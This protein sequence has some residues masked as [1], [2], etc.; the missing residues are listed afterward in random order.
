MAFELR[1]KSVFSFYKILLFDS[2][3]NTIIITYTIINTTKLN[4]LRINLSF[5]GY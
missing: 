4:F 5:K 2:I 1:P 3:I